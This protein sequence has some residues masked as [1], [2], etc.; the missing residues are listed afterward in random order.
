MMFHTQH[1]KGEKSNELVNLVDKIKM[2]F[3]LIN[4]DDLV[5]YLQGYSF[6]QK[7]ETPLIAVKASI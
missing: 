6:S 7:R 3:F 2:I 5:S 1:P 4:N